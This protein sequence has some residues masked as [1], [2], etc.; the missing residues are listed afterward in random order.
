MNSTEKRR[1][2]I[3][4]VNGQDGAYLSRLLLEKGY[5]VIGTS[6]NAQASSFQNLRALGIFNSVDKL[7]IGAG[8]LPQRRQ[9]CFQ[10]G[11]A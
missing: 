9:H 4:G 6:R 1:A 3:C 11:S 10:I 8:G 2:L 7:S 5:R